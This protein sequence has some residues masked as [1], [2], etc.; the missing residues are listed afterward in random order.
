MQKEKKRVFPCFYATSLVI[1]V[2]LISYCIDGNVAFEHKGEDIKRGE[3]KAIKDN[4]G[5]EQGSQVSSVEAFEQLPDFG[6]INDV[7]ERKHEFFEFMYP[8]IEMENAKVLKKRERLL[9]LYEKQHNNLD[10]SPEDLKW[11]DGLVSLYKI[12]KKQEEYKWEV[13]LRRVDIVPVQ[14]ALI[15]SAKETGWGTS[16]FA[17]VGNNMFG[18]WCFSELRGIVPKQRGSD[19]N[20]RV[21]TF[22]TVKDSV[23]SYIHNINTSDA[24][25][26]LRHLRF[27]Q[28]QAGEVPDSYALANGLLR[29]SERREDYVKE[30]QAMILHNKPLMD[31]L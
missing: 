11:I 1:L 19:A 2:F 13:L 25:T 14:L 21:A 15:Q 7:K 17:R 6:S 8:I 29:Y 9:V 30:V 20:H 27:E 16:R 24:Y 31:S 10:Q 12:K 26:R 18:Q 5:V 22:K 23:R 3:E 28:R 4:K